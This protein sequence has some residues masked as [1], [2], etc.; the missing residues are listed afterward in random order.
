MII[1]TDAKEA[2]QHIQH[3][4]IIET[5]NKLDTEETYFYVIYDRY[6]KPTAYTVFNNKKLA[7]ILTSRT[8][9]KKTR[10]ATLS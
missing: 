2:F 4:L 1:S 5:L 6:D 8:R 9:N 10:M 7:K 3:T